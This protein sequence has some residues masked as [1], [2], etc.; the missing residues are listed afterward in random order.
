MGLGI[1]HTH[2]QLI[3]ALA[4][5]VFMET[6][7]LSELESLLDSFT[8]LY[9]FSGFVAGLLVCSVVAVAYALWLSR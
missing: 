5:E 7:T 9:F 4:F 3:V 1:T 6:Y 8:G 2:I